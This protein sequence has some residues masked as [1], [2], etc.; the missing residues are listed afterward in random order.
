LKVAVE[1]P[2]ALKENVESSTAVALGAV[3]VVMLFW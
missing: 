2:V 1:T 3:P